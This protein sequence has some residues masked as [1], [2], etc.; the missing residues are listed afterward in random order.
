MTKKDF[1]GLANTLKQCPELHYT[2]YLLNMAD[3]LEKRHPKFNK[4]LWLSYI[5]GE[6]GL[7]GRKIKNEK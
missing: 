7:N 3:D 1:I 6:C 4:Q 5:R 2:K